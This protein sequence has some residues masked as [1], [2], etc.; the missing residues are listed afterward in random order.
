MQIFGVF[1][2]TMLWPS[3]SDS[4]S[5]KGKFSS[6]F[7]LTLCKLRVGPFQ[8]R[9]DNRR[10]GPAIDQ[11]RRLHSP[12]LRDQPG[13]DRLAISP[14]HLNRLSWLFFI[15][16]LF[17]SIVIFVTFHSKILPCTIACNA[18]GFLLK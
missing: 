6:K 11:L 5:E 1:W 2:D 3:L 10:W 17:D 13:D 12:G 16:L 14:P 8:H 4:V 18:S 7:R 9:E 15:V